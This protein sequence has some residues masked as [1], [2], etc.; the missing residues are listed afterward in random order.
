MVELEWMFR[1]LARTVGEK[2]IVLCRLGFQ[3]IQCVMDDMLSSFANR[4]ALTEEEQQIVVIDEK[5]SAL[6]RTDHVFLVGR[7]LS[8]NMPEHR[9]V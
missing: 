8:Q 3:V 1:R 7:V 9:A 6:L 2:S 4:L 5:E